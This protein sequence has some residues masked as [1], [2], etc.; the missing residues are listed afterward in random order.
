MSGLH[1]ECPCVHDCLCLHVRQHIHQCVISSAAHADMSACEILFVHDFAWA[2]VLLHIHQ[3]GWS[4]FFPLNHWWDCN[5]NT[6]P[7][8]S[9]PIFCRQRASSLCH[10][11]ENQ[12][13]VRTKHRQQTCPGNWKKAPLVT[14]WSK[15]HRNKQSQQRL[16]SYIY[17]F[18][19]EWSNSNKWK[20]HSLFGSSLCQNVHTFIHIFFWLVLLVLL[21]ED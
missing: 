4:V 19:I 6:V 1:T 10:L 7:P 21:F 20:G 15:R 9:F 18:S 11:Q 2:C 17:V 13:A 16:F 3:H 8:I 14:K 12:Y 5:S